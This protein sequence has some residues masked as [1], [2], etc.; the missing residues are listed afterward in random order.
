MVYDLEKLV[1][2]EFRKLEG[3]DLLTVDTEKVTEDFFNMLTEIN[4]QDFVSILITSG[5]IPDLYGAD[6]KEETLFTKLCEALEVNWAT[7]MGFEAKTVTQKSSY[8][9][10]V[11]RI[12]NKTIVSDTKSFRLGRSQQAPNVNDFVKPEDYSKWA[13]RHSGEKLGGLVVYPQ[14]HEWTKKSD[15]H[16]YCSDKK[17]PILMLPFHYLAY[18]LSRKG[19]FNSNDLE[20]LW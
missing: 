3:T 10:V 2:D 20:K 18:F 17:N 5:Y 19:T 1:N 8:E 16:I 11:I 12:N 9:D 7:R 14:L 13:E 15:A 6:S 4:D